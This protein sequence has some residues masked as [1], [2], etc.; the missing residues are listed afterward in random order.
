MDQPARL[1]ENLAIFKISHPASL[2]A[3]SS[4]CCTPRQNLFFDGK[5]KLAGKNPTK[6]SDCYTPAPAA[7][8]AF[9]S[10]VANIIVPFIAS[11]STNSSVVKHL[12]DDLQEIVRTIFKAKPLF[13]L[14]PALVSAPVVAAAP[15]YEGQCKR[16]LK[17]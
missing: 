6:N 8:R 15:Y 2:M 1:E 10:V 4:A 17:A 7:T 13:S 3:Q 14:A 16:P 11:G 12:E 9:I 5:D